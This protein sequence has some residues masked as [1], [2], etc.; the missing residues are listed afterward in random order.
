MVWVILVVSG[1]GAIALKPWTWKSDPKAPPINQLA[2]AESQRDK[3]IQDAA[4]DK[5]R[6]ESATAKDKADLTSQTSY[7]QEM[8]NGAQLAFK[9]IPT[10][11]QGPE[12]VLG[13]SLLDR[14]S[15]GLS[16]AIGD[17][18]ADKQA[19]ILSIVDGVLS[20]AQE[21]V[22]AANKALAAKDQELKATTSDRDTLKGQLPGLKATLDAKEQLVT[23]KSNLVDNLTGQVVTYAKAKEKDSSLISKLEASANLFFK[24]IIG[25]GIAYVFLAFILPVVGTVIGPQAETILHNISGYIL[26]PFT[27]STL[28][29]SV[30]AATTT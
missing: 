23:S 10:A 6:Y 20:K 5:A 7:S 16:K 18:P 3:A 1:A 25:L 4:T 27:H 19:E 15:S 26:S 13:M 11:L 29:K 12:Y 9:R 24:I 8:V 14:A 17:L 21:Q 28:K 2:V 30:I 22:D